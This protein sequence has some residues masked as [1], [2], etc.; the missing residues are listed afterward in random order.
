MVQPLGYNDAILLSSLV[1]SC[2]DLQ[3]EWDSFNSCSR[4]IH[5]WLVVSY[6]CVICFR[7]THLLGMQTASVADVGS[8]IA[9]EGPPGDFLLDLRHKGAMPR[10]LAYFTWLIALPFFMLWTF[11]GTSWLWQV[12]RDTPQC[13][14]TTT[15][16]WFSGLWLALC[17]VWIIIHV[18][19]G[20]VAWVLERRVRRAEVDLREIADADTISRWGQVSQLS[21]YRSLGAG[22][23]SGGLSPTEIKALPSETSPCAC[24]VEA[25]MGETRE[26]S[27][28]LNALEPGDSVRCLPLCGHTFH[29]SCIDL[30]LLRSADCPLCKRSVRG[31]DTTP[32]TP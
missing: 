17:Y 28:C 19:L 31:G 25:E 24:D 27:I 4:P 12:T 26:C 5:M 21:G 16:L 13:V 18:A 1:Y 3:F 15:H 2:V 32:T 11:I 10:L 6:V 9:Q 8:A 22:Q 7:L 29:R 30:W 14:P 20:V 23:A